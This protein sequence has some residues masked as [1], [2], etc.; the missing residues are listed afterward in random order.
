MINMVRYCL[1]A[2]FPFVIAFVTLIF[3]ISVCL[4]IM[5]L[6]LD[7]EVE[8]YGKDLSHFE[9]VLLQTFRT[10][11]GE[12]AQPI[13]SKLMLEDEGFLRSL[14]MYTIWIIWYT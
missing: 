10:I 3:V 8:D 2:L 1:E 14:K 9:K 12:L 11:I 6:E 5:Q 13:Y 4:F 7:G